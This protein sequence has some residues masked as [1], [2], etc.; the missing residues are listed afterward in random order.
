M[1]YGRT[2][3]WEVENVTTQSLAEGLAKIR[4]DESKVVPD[5]ALLAQLQLLRELRE[6]GVLSGP[7][8]RGPLGNAP[9]KSA[10]RIIWSDE[11]TARR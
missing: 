1:L 11:P 2:R 6:R 3:G 8:Y 9:P 5:A 7:Q 4:A 10:V